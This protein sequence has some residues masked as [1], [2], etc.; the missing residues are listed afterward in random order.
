V[1]W[2]SGREWSGGREWSVERV[3]LGIGLGLVE[4]RAGWVTGRGC[5]WVRALLTLTLTLE[6]GLGQSLRRWRSSTMRP[7]QRAYR[8]VPTR[9]Q[10]GSKK[11]PRRCVRGNAPLV[12]G[13][14]LP[15]PPPR[16]LRA[17]RPGAVHTRPRR[18]CRCCCCCCCCCRRL[19][20]LRWS[21]G[22]PHGWSPG[23]ACRHGH[24]VREAVAILP[25][26]RRSPR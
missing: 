17:L 6:A 1:G 16:P 18:C 19:L 7:R 4:W 15:P 20:L 22:E 8:A 25:S 11:V 14:G 21:R 10:E 13:H 23:A 26:R 5:A 3:G 9:F 12:R 24:A 2:S